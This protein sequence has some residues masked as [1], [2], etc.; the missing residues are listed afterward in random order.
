MTHDE[1]YVLPPNHPAFVSESYDELLKKVDRDHEL[2]TY[3]NSGLINGDITINTARQHWFQGNALRAVVELAGKDIE[4]ESYV[5]LD[6]YDYAMKQ[7]IQAI[8][9]ELG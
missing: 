2:T 5:W 8:E 6:G 7:I 1:G 3:L 9:K 4:H